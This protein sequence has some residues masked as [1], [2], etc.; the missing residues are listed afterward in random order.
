MELRDA[1]IRV[2]MFSRE[3]SPSDIPNSSS[4]PD[5]STWGEALADFPS[6]HCDISS[7]FKDQSII[8]NIEGGRERSNLYKRLLEVQQFQGLSGAM[9]RYHTITNL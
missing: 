5:A 2:W 8:A 3:N 6:K 7:H 9:M 4:C 1:G